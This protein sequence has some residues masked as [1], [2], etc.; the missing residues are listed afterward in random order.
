MIKGKRGNYPVVSGDEP[1][2]ATVVLGGQPEA[3][4]GQCGERRYDCSFTS[5]GKTLKCTL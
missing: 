1:I 2:L 4:I 5:G 3:E